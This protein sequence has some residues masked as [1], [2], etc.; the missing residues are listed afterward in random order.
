MAWLCSSCLSR[1]SL[2]EPAAA[3]LRGFH[4]SERSDRKPFAESRRSAVTKLQARVGS[5]LGLFVGEV[6]AVGLQVVHDALH[7][8]AA[9]QP[10]GGHETELTLFDEVS[11]WSL[12]TPPTQ[13]QTNIV[14]TVDRISADI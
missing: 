13:S 4:R 1:E 9:E 14:E 2:T 6:R 12:K 10:E 11:D 5:N 8:A 3:L 7:A